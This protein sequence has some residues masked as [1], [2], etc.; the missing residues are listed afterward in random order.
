VFALFLK[1]ENTSMK[2][3]AVDKNNLWITRFDMT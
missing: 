1:S 2:T 3:N